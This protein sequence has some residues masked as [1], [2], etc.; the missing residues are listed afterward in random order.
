MG[1]LVKSPLSELVATLEVLERLGVKPECLDL[2]R[3]DKD[4]AK[5]VAE[6]LKSCLMFSTSTLDTSGNLFQ[7]LLTACCQYQVHHD[8]TE[9][10]FPLVDDGTNDKEILELGFNCIV[11]GYEGET[12][13]K[14]GGYKLVGMK[15][16]MEYIAK[17]PDAQKSHSLI[18]LG[19]QWHDGNGIVVPYFFLS[20]G[21]R[22]FSLHWLNNKFFSSY[23]VLVVRG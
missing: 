12:L 22:R 3:R 4:F 8:I 5:K 15:R 13:L 6:T 2:V 20:G 16:A 10:H 1:S 19:A 14:K 17:K 18:V 23:R 11:N 7:I 9:G 21:K